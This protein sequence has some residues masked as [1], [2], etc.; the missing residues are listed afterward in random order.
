MRDL[1]F[2]DKNSDFTFCIRSVIKVAT[3][4]DLDN[5]NYVMVDEYA[6]SRHDFFNLLHIIECCGYT[7]QQLAFTSAIKH[8]SFIVLDYK[9]YYDFEIEEIDNFIKKFIDNRKKMLDKLYGV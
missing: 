3:Q 1:V 8:C 7:S 5:P 2:W 4:D 9:G 6:V